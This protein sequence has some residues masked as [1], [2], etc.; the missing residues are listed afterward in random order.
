MGIIPPDYRT[1]LVNCVRPLKSLDAPSVSSSYR[2]ERENI[3]IWAETSQALWIHEGKPC[4]EV[5]E[6]EI[7]ASATILGMPLSSS[8]WSPNGI[9]PFGLALSSEKAGCITTMRI[10][11]G[12][13]DL[14]YTNAMGSGYSTLFAKHLA[15]NCLPFAECSQEASVETIPITRAFLHKI[16]SGSAIADL[17]IG[18][19]V[20][21]AATRY[22]TNLP[23]SEDN[24]YYKAFCPPQ[25]LS[26]PGTI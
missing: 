4:I 17:P 11:Y 2:T 3:K 23:S 1:Y 14:H 7:A 26:Q 5:S 9:G 24:N 8:D 22:L 18:N 13:R 16:K 6:E 25:V 21:N 19:A 10:V 15:C 20:S 12:R